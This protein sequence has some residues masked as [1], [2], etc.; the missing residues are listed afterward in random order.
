VASGNLTINKPSGTV[1]GDVMIAAIAVRPETVTIG[2]PSGWTLIRRSDNPNA[3]ANT[4]AV[5]RKVAG[6]AEPASYTWTLSTNTGAVGGILSFTGVNNTTPVD[7]ENGQITANALTHT[8]P[9][10]TTNFAN[11]MLV[12][13]HAFTSAATWT[14]PGGMNEGVDVASVAVPNAGGI[15][16]EMDYVIQ[17]AAGATGDKTATASANSDVGNA[18][19]VAL[20]P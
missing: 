4:L 7:V 6:G 16:L 19:I 1:S 11:T 10:V 12:T 20:R 2:A 8:A 14:P 3:N 13:S 18:H 17:S 5:Y 15:S 9:G